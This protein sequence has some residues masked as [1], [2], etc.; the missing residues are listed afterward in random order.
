MKT[1][2]IVGRKLFYTSLL[3]YLL[4]AC[5][6]WLVP[7]MS[8]LEDESSLVSAL[9]GCLFWLGILVGSILFCMAWS[10]VKKEAAYQKI[11]STQKPGCLGFFRN[12][13]AAIND[14]ILLVSWIL[15]IVS[16]TFLTFPDILVL[17]CMFV[18]LYTLFLHFLL[19]GRVYSYISKN[20]GNKK[21]ERKNERQN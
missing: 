21:K 15:V 7:L 18:A 3:G 8:L 11:K 13:K 16:N 14:I 1:N 12:Q 6:V 2:R 5:S 10:K 19:N 4:A 17:L 20:N 9:V